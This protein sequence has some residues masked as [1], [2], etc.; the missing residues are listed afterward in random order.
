MTT[1]LP[2]PVV[3]AEGKAEGKRDLL[4][5]LLALK[6]GLLPPGLVAQLQKVTD[7]TVFDRLSGFLLSASTLSE[8]QAQASPFLKPTDVL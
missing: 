6:F 8:F 4:M 3:A 2:D 5:Q 1:T 7:A